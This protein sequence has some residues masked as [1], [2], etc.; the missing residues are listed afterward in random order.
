MVATIL[1]SNGPK[2]E[3]RGA[4]TDAAQDGDTPRRPHLRDSTHEQSLRMFQNTPPTA[5]I[6]Q[7]LRTAI[8]AVLRESKHDVRRRGTLHANAHTH[9]TRRALRVGAIDNCDVSNPV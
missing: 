7:T 3:R 1:A 9:W 6:S 8:D 2:C 5:A 4:K